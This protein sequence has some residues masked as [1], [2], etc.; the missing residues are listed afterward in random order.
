MNVYDTANR[1]ATE[2]KSSEEYKTHGAAWLSGSGG[3]REIA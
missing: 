1:L 3:A 2:I